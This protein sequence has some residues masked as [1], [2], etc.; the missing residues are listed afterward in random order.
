[1]R[2]SEYDGVYYKVLELPHAEVVIVHVVL[3]LEQRL[4]ELL[5]EML[6]VGVAGGARAH[7][8]QGP[9]QHHVVGVLD[10]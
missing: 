8:L 10:R 1:M 4:K 5:P 3:K 2:G 6:A 9:R 7:T